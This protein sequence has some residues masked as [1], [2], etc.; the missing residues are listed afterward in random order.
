MLSLRLLSRLT[1]SFFTRVPR[2]A[3]HHMPTH[4]S[5]LPVP[6]VLSNSRAP[7]LVHPLELLVVVVLDGLPL[8]LEGGRDEAGLGR[9]QLRA[10]GDGA[11][12]LEPLQAGLA[13]VRAQLLQQGRNQRLV[14]AQLVEVGGVL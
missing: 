5:D 3:L 8:E 7:R 14:A 6:F 13:P 12:Q 9:P 2:G 1:A 4:V 10:D 11:G